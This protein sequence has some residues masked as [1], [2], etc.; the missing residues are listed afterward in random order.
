MMQEGREEAKE[1]RN[2]SKE[3]KKVKRYEMGDRMGKRERREGARGKARRN[4]C[5]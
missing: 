5:R 4:E 2:G 1:G 3:R